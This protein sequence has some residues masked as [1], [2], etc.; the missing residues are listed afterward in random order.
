M[1]D[2][3]MADINRIKIYDNGD[4]TADRYAIVF[5]NRKS[6]RNREGKWLYEALA[7]CEDPF[8]PC[9]VGMHVESCVGS[10]LG[11]RIEFDALPERVQRFVKDNFE[12]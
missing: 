10:H 4:K 8:H 9:G 12:V 3:K 6:Q 2:K 1:K 7:S 11:K 5:V